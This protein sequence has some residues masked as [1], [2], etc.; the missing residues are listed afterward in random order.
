VAAGGVVRCAGGV[1]VGGG[2]PCA[3]GVAAGGV[4]RCAGGAPAASR[5]GA[6]TVGVA[7]RGCPS[8][9]AQTL[10][11]SSSMSIRMLAVVAMSKP[12][13]AVLQAALP[14]PLGHLRPCEPEEGGLALACA[15]IV[16]AEPLEVRDGA[17]RLAGGEQALSEAEQCGGRGGRGWVAEYDADEGVL[18]L[19]GVGGEHAAQVERAGAVG[20]RRTGAAGLAKLRSHC[21]SVLPASVKRPLLMRCCTRSSAVSCACAAAAPLRRSRQRPGART[22]ARVF[23]CSPRCGALLDAEQQLFHYLPFGE[24]R[25]LEQPVGA[26]QVIERVLDCW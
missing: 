16:G 21:A 26:K 17:A 7:P 5:A 11:R 4:V 8:A 25:R 1:A 3:G 20:G 23:S 15:G 9:A 18:G 6:G 12:S 14:L 22:G 2:V 10:S 13:R 24:R 19:P